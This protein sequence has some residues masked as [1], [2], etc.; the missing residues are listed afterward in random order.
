MLHVMYPTLIIFIPYVSRCIPYIY[1]VESKN[2]VETHMSHAFYR[3][4]P[5]AKWWDDVKSVEPLAV[6]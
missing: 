1:R 6:L 3:A 5:E 2:V 4:F